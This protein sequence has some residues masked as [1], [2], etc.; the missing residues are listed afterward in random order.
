MGSF[1]VKI[2]VFQASPSL[3]HNIEPIHASYH[4]TAL[5]PN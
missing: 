5:L 3:T 2:T 1:K 4:L